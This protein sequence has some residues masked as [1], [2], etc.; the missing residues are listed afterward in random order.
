M[1]A[2]PVRVK[3]VVPP[4]VWQSVWS[5][6]AFAVGLGLTVKTR[7]SVA[8]PQLGVALLVA[9]SRSVTVPVPVILMPVLAA[10]G[11]VKV[12]AALP[13]ELCTDHC[14]VPSVTVPL[15]LKAVV[16]PAA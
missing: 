10:F 5:A 6:P 15:K 1:V 7:S 8:V 2:V 11:V 4:V 12:A 9:V 13:V 16:P 14:G 3:A